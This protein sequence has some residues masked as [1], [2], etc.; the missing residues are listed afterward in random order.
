MK[1]WCMASRQMTA[2]MLPEALVVWPVKPF[3]LDTGG[4]SLPKTRCR[5][6]LSLWS[7]LGVPVPW[8]FT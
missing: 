7:L 5:A 2:S 3:V 8:A 1:P 6:T 4:R